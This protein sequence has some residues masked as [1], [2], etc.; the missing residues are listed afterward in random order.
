MEG[1]VEGGRDGRRKE[2]RK[3]SFLSD[4]QYDLLLSTK[5]PHRFHIR[6]RTACSS[7]KSPIKPLLITYVG[8]SL[9]FSQKEK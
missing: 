5:N 9:E 3:H 6:T 8:Y 7:S 4:L 1:G 2:G